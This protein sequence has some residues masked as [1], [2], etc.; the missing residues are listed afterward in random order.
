MQLDLNFVQKT[1]GQGVSLRTFEEEEFGSP[2]SFLGKMNIYPLPQSS[3][4]ACCEK[5]SMIGV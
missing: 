4:A 2:V 5:K 1:G 3:P